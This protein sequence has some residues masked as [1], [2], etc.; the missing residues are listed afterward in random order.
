MNFQFKSVVYCIAFAFTF[1]SCQRTIAFPAHGNQNFCLLAN[2]LGWNWC[3]CSVSI[4]LSKIVSFTWKS[5]Q[6]ESIPIGCVPPTLVT[7]TRCQYCSGGRYDILIPP[8]MPTPL[9]YLPSVIP[10]L[11]IPTP[12]IP[13]PEGTWDQRYLTP[14]PPRDLGPEIHLPRKGPGTR[15]TPRTDIHLWKH[16][17]PATSFAGGKNNR[18]SCEDGVRIV[19]ANYKFALLGLRSWKGSFT[20][21]LKLIPVTSVQSQI[22]TNMK[23]YSYCAKVI[24]N[25]IAF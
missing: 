25:V 7:T 6:Q 15:D 2:M 5:E 16:Y 4:V 8:G 23:A 3:P 13:S 18:Y 9:V 11:W 22:H 12:W 17:L 14:P 21:T 20:F 1:A 19:K 10:T 24:A